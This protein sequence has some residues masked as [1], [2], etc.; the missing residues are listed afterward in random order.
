MNRFFRC[1][2]ALAAAGVVV[3]LG[4]S[5]A[6]AHEQRTVGAYQ[7]T[8]GWQHEPTYVGA[9]NAVAIFIHDA[10]GNAIDDLGSPPSL[11]VTVTSGSQTNPPLALAASFDPDTGLGTH[12]EFDAYI[13]P[14]APGD[15]AFHFT[16]TI[17][18]QA[19]DEKFTSGPKT[20]DTVHDPTAVQ[21]PVKTPSVS[22]LSALTNRLNS[23]VDS[24][25]AA[26]KTDADKANSAH[27][28]AVIGVIL[29]IVGIVLG[30]GLGG[31]GLLAGRRAR[32]KTEPPAKQ[33]T[34]Q[35]VKA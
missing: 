30:A 31:A 18:G 1:T 6:F 22:D 33:Q 24:A 32:S 29:G 19:V 26:A 9:Q 14:T 11:Q 20:F 2:A 17:N 16:G 8:V 35:P 15:Y 27:D 10:K 7:F 4:A 12:S 13:T 3:L 23:R 34:E 5:P 25:Q 21:F 28:L